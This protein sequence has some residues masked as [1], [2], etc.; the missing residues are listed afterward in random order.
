M[1]QNEEVALKGLLEALQFSPENIPLR[2]H[3]ANIYTHLNKLEE[4][5][6]QLLKALEFAPENKALKLRLAELF[7][8]RKKTSAAFVI[9]EELLQADPEQAETNLLH[10]RLLFESGDAAE[11]LEKYMLATKQNPALKNKELEAAITEKAHPGYSEFDFKMPVTIQE[12]D[13]A[14]EVERPKIKFSDVGGMER[15]KEEIEM[16][17]IHPLKHPELYKAYGKK[18]G[19]GILMY[20]PPGCGKTLLARAT[21][22]EVNA[23]FISVGINDILDMW[24]GNSEK[25]LHNIFELARSKAPCVLFFDEVDALGASRTDMRKSGGRHLINQFLSELDG[26]EYSNE[27]VLILAATNTPWNMDSAF[28]RP[29]RFDR[30]VFVTPPDQQAK[31]AILEV[32]LKDKPTQKVN[33]EALAKKAKD[34]SGADL[35]AVV[36]VAIE[37]KLRESMK[38]GLPL[39]LEQNDLVKAI[40]QVRPSTKEWFGTARNYALYSNENGLYNEILDY[41]QIKK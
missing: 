1:N 17:I 21:A 29:G 26:V 10:A 41:L 8:K 22:G 35:K 11:A 32:L 16:K 9:V 18:I 27:G 4:A 40:E 15:V 30:I 39:P 33:T 24:I 23:S 13:A 19:G 12:D 7:Y 3:V 36:D 31:Q 6:Q 37:A 38:K 2:L 14:A 28:R 20:G 5:E 34:F 25:N